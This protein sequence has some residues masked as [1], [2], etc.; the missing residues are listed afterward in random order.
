[1]NIKKCLFVDIKLLGYYLFV[2]VLL[3]YSSQAHSSVLVEYVIIRYLTDQQVPSRIL[4]T[5]CPKVLKSLYK[6]GK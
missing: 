3:G 4:Q 2:P 6:S 5:R 1:M